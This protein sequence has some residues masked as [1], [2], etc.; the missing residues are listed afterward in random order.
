MTARPHIMPDYGPL[1]QSVG[2]PS[3]AAL[4]ASVGD[5]HLT[6]LVL[7]AA[8]CLGMIAALGLRTLERRAPQR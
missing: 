6:P 4:A 2:P 7:A 3:A 5:W 8:A 1:G